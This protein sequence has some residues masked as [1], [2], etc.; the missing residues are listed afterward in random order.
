M[1]RI[2]VGPVLAAIQRI[3]AGTVPNHLSA[4]EPG[5][6]VDEVGLP[7]GR[8]VRGSIEKVVS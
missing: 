3:L 6:F 4:F 1:Q 8:V 7:L 2:E 5:F